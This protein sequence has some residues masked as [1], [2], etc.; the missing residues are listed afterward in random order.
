MALATKFL[1]VQSARDGPRHWWQRLLVDMIFRLFRLNW[2][3]IV[4][5]KPGLNCHTVLYNT[6]GHHHHGPGYCVPVYHLGHTNEIT[7]ANNNVVERLK[8]LESQ[9]IWL[10]DT[11]HNVTVKAQNLRVMHNEQKEEM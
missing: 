2:H 8:S 9:N 6:T 3:R 11:L 7:L 4:P 1:Q 10:G 5:V